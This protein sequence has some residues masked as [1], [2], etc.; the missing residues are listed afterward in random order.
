MRVE[1]HAQLRRPRLREQRLRRI[2]RQLHG[3]AHVQRQRA[4][5]V[6][7]ELRRQAMRSRRV[8][9]FVRLLPVG[10][11]LQR[12]WDRLLLSRGLLGL[13]DELSRRVRLFEHRV[14]IT[15]PI[16]P[17]MQPEHG[18]LRLR[19]DDVRHV[20]LP[21][22]DDLLPNKRVL[23]GLRA[24]E[25]GLQHVL[26]ARGTAMLSTML[27]AAR[28][29]RTPPPRTVRSPAVSQSIL[30]WRLAHRSSARVRCVDGV[31]IVEREGD[32]SDDGAHRTA[33]LG[34]AV[35]RQVVTHHRARP[36]RA[37]GAEN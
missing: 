34:I 19:G 7:S 20:V 25:R 31:A 17:H 11:L 12:H 16:E 15:V 14:P 18:Q 8:R 22:R 2:V 35:E 9:R 27:V 37:I 32:L 3:A 24:T 36:F 26:S 23:H 29:G 4:V 13:D 5:R 10:A 30:C 21:R 6:H 33:V 1:L 28:I